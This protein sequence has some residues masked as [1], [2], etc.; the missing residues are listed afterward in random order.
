MNPAPAEEFKSTNG[1]IS[2]TKLVRQ[3]RHDPLLNFPHIVLLLCLKTD[4]ESDLHN[5]RKDKVHDIRPKF[6]S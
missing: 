2:Y 5:I 3:K 4:E 6:R 1:I